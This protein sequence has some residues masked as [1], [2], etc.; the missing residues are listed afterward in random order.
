MKKLL[1][2]LGILLLLAC[3]AWAMDL[4]WDYPSDWDDIIGYTIYFTDGIDN[5]NK[6][7]VKDD[8]VEDGITVEEPVVEYADLGFGTGIELAVNIDP[9]LFAC[10]S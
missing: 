7:V 2:I 1:G 6:S 5:Y 3:P 9:L 4:Q 8:L 10:P